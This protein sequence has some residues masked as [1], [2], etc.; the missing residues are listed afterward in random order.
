MNSYVS[1][2]NNQKTVATTHPLIA[3]LDNR[4]ANKELLLSW[5]NRLLLE[6]ALIC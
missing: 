3:L 6:M 2:V 1:L 4:D 5:I